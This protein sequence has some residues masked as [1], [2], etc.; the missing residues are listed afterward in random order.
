MSPKCQHCGPAASCCDAVA[1]C[2]CPA[3]PVRFCTPTVQTFGVVLAKSPG[4]TA[5]TLGD[6]LHVCAECDQ[7]AAAATP[8]QRAGLGDTLHDW[9]AAVGITPERVRR[10]FGRCWCETIRLTLN[11]WWPYEVTT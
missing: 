9:F 4:V 5:E 6:A 8:R 7:Y 2:N 1:S 11:R 10:I 3:V